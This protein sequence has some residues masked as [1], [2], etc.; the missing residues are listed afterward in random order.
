MIIDEDIDDDS[1]NNN[2]HVRDSLMKASMKHEHQHKKKKSK[3][4]DGTKFASN[5]KFKSKRK[6]LNRYLYVLGHYEQLGKTLINFMHVGLL[7]SFINRKIVVPFVRNSRLC[8]LPTGWIGS[9]RK[10][11][12]EFLV[13]DNYFNLNSLERIFHRE[14]FADMSNFN[15]FHDACRHKKDNTMLYFFY[16][17]SKQE[18]KRYLLLSEE[19]YNDIERQFAANSG[20]TNC[21]HIEQRVKS[22]KRMNGIQFSNAY[23]I[24]AELVTDIN[25]LDVLTNS[26]K[27]LS[28]FLWRGYGPQRTHFNLSLPLSYESYLSKLSF[29]DIIMEEARDF[30]QNSFANEPFIGIQIRSER[31][32]GWYGLEK[33]KHCLDLV[34]K[35]ASIFVVKKKIEHIFVSA[36]IEKHGS[37]QLIQML[38]STT[39]ERAKEYFRESF[40]GLPVEFY[41]PDKSRGLIYNDAGYVALTQM[42]ILSK[43]SHL[44]TLGAGTFQSWVTSHFK[45]SKNQSQD[46]QPWSL[47]RIC[48]VELKDKR[49]LKSSTNTTVPT[50]S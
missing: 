4:W 43:S 6:W 20:W 16:S 35:V 21:M 13:M 41:K 27:C 30:I 47:T 33:F 14:R 44:I 39:L 24:N 3:K 40:E 28:V 19:E 18:L 5:F 32:L 7:A 49:K 23:C 12:R 10:K 22:G 42:E 9:L 1:F 2:K 38:N 46:G 25:A 36:D 29:S 34:V 48:S 45:D 31:Q 15:E 37:D 50:K 8:G 26:S 17:G 11:S